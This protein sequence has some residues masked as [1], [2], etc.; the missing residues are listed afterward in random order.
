MIPRSMVRW[1]VGLVQIILLNLLS[2]VVTAA[3]TST[4]LIVVS[5]D[6]FRT[7]YLQRNSTW[8]MNDLRRNGTSAE[9]LRNV[10][11]T[12]TFPNHHSI[13]TGVYPN[14][15]G[16]MANGLYDHGRGKIEYSFELFHFNEE[17][18]PIWVR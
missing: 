16:V 2:N 4:V 10:F 6:A 8:F 7:E 13:A 3:D 15:H 18:V 17:I 11:P 14:V 12:K 5:Y 1:F 9:F